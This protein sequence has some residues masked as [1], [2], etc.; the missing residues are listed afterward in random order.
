MK[1]GVKIAALV[2]LCAM[3]LLLSV[4]VGSVPI[5]VSDT[6]RI[7]AHKLF[8]AALPETVAQNTVAILWTIRL[9]RA[10]LAFCVG[11]LLSVSGTV[12]QSVLRNPL[13]SSY[14]LGI[15]SGASLGA[16]AVILTGFTLPFLGGY[17][18]PAAGLVSGLLAVAL[19]VTFAARVDRGMRTNTIILAGMV[20]SLFINALLT[21]LYTFAKEQ[22]QRMVLWQMGSFAF[23]GWGEV[24][25]LTPVAVIG[26]LL[27]TFFARELDMLTFGE[28]EAGAMGVDTRRFKWLL[29]ALS[30]A[31]TGCAVAFAGVIGF[32]DLIAPHV[33]RRFFG[34]RHRLVVPLSA[35]FGGGFMALCDM[36]A[37]TIAAPVELPVGAI[38][39]LV[40]APF[41]AYV[42]FLRRKAGG[43]A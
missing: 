25:L 43:A 12:M 40:G 33:V 31:L 26:V 28:E 36:V 23:K 6:A 8:G 9:P 20:F 13:A 29:L 11:A 10:L 19:A 15:S 42:F 37:R 39:A 3:S 24:W 30:A 18:L 7:I 34:A 2:F 35:L 5:G 16:A 32:V 14:T 21:L 41:F 17:T 4:A 1:A 38:S 22:A 27:L